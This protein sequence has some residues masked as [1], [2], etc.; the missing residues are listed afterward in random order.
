VEASF[1][2]DRNQIIKGEVIG[3]G[4][5]GTVFV[6]CYKETKVA[7]KVIKPLMMSKAAFLQEAFIMSRL[8]H[9]NLVSFCGISTE[10][11]PLMLVSEFMDNGNLL[12]FLRRKDH[13]L[14]TDSEGY[15]NQRILSDDDLW[16]MAEQ[17]AK[18][19][20][21]LES[22]DLIHRDLAARNILVAN[23]DSLKIADFGLSRIVER[24][25]GS[26]YYARARIDLPIRWTAPEGLSAKKKF[27]VKSD[28]WSFGI[29]LFEVMTFGK[30]P[31]EG[32]GVY[33]VVSKVGADYIMPQP[34]GCTDR[35]YGMMTDCWKRQPEE[36]PSFK[37]IHE[38]CVAALIVKEDRGEHHLHV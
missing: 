17:V 2:L 32:M 31:Y 4:H 29:L 6:G 38:R 36:R 9:P 37:E 25:N 14:Q 35:A 10:L 34:E 18:G 16:A 8:K 27:T 21:Y 13:R 12:D 11:E 5:F 20:V 26:I 28:V 24:A 33:E 19:M 15:Q 7:I 22:Q 23:D 1:E 3:N 30:Q